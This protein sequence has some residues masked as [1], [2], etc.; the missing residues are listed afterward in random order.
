MKAFKYFHSKFKDSIESGHFFVNTFE[1]IRDQ[2]EDGAISDSTEAIVENLSGDIKIS[3][4]RLPEYQRALADL[5]EL[6]AFHIQGAAT[7]IS[8][9]NCTFTTRL[10]NAHMYCVSTERN[11]AYWRDLPEKQGGPY[12]S[13]V[14]ISDFGE[15]SERVRRS[16]AEVYGCDFG[17]AL[18]NC[19]FESNKGV[20]ADGSTANP[21]YFRKPHGEGFEEQHEMRAVFISHRPLTLE[22]KLL[23]IEVADL[24]TLHTLGGSAPKS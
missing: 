8:I 2:F 7:N 9:S 20:I 22:P 18:E 4:A 1:S 21:S 19:V 23:N 16:L 6:G 24:I 14:E 3:D 13:C 15:F 12:G 17:I 10:Q 11:D 5:S